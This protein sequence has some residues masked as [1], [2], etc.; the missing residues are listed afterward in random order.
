MDGAFQDH[1]PLPAVASFTDLMRFSTVVTGLTLTA[2][3]TATPADAESTIHWQPDTVV[4]IQ[5]G[6]A[7]GRMARLPDNSIL[8]AYSRRGTI[9]VRKSKDDGR[10]WESETFAAEYAHGHA[11]NAELLVLRS[12]SALLLY[13]ERPTDRKSPYAIAVC[14]SDDA[15]HAWKNHRRIYSAGT[16]F[17]NGCWEPAAIE[18]PSG[19]IQ[20]FFANEAPYRSSAE[21]QITRLRSL[22]GG[23]TWLEPQ[24]ISFRPGHRDGMPVPLLLAGG[25]R[26][27]VAIEDN[28]LAGQFKPAIISIKP[29]GQ[30]G[31]LPVCADDDRRQSALA[32]P[33][34]G[35]VYA[36]APYLVRLPS[37][38]TVLSVQSTEGRGTPH[39]YPNSRMVVYVGDGTAHEF[40]CRSVPFHTLTDAPGLWNSL[41]VKDEETI[42]AIS[43]TMIDG[44]RGI[45]AMDGL[46]S[47]EP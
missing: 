38:E 32:Q 34:P 17:E 28:G 8:C 40:A 6:A 31:S 19:E 13:N 5:R 18:L 16:E 47:R 39:D 35:H 42:T 26:I 15:G 2:L 10:T 11:T 36:G 46:V 37:G 21:Q 4:L 12:G 3:L 20:L 44:M 45:W 14:T 24:A 41:F 27:A 9:Y 25:K 33:L 1:V 23:I 30:P 43:G 29:S 7:Y 22:D